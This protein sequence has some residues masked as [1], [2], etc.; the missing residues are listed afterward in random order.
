MSFISLDDFGVFG[1]TGEPF[2]RGVSFNSKSF[3]EFSFSNGGVT[4]SDIDF[5]FNGSG[6][7]LPDGGKGFAVSTPRGVEFNE[8]GFGG[9]SNDFFEVFFSDDYNVVFNFFFLLLFFFFG[10]FFFFF[11]FGGFGGIFSGVSDSGV[12]N[13]F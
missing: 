3:G 9:G 7:F 11:F 13:F 12:S 2:K 6:E 1:S 4:F 10:F 8:P 5:S